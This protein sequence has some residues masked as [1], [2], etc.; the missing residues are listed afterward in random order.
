MYVLKVTDKKYNDWG[1]CPK[2]SLCCMGKK[3]GFFWED[4]VF[5]TKEEA[6]QYIPTLLKSGWFRKDITK[7]NFEIIEVKQYKCLC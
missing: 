3:K 1:Y 6:E 2:G 4:D 7:D 5:Y